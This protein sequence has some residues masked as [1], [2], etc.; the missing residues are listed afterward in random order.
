M[1]PVTAQSTSWRKSSF[2]AI[3]DCVA[4]RRLDDGAIGIRNTNDHAAATLVITT[5]DM[6]DW[7]SRIKAGA[8]DEIV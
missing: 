8:F 5:W 1:D 6:A 7:L 2:S 4:V 3:Q